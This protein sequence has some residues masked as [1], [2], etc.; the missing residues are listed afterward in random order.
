MNIEI[1]F[2]NFKPITQRELDIKLGRIKVKHKKPKWE[3]K[4]IRKYFKKKKKKQKEDRRWWN[5]YN[6]YIN[7]KDWLKKKI[8]F[9]KFLKASKLKRVCDICGCKK[10]LHVHHLSY[11]NFMNEEMTDLQLLCYAC[12]KTKHPNKEM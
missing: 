11:K 5:S 7:S 3:G 8:E 2:W 4:H 12:H 6:E 9:F 10:R 1:N